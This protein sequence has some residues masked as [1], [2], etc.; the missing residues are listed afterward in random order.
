MR[1]DK[2]GR[3]LDFLECCGPKAYNGLIKSLGATEQE[4]A[5][6]LLTDAMLPNSTRAADGIYFF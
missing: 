1:D 4:H 5:A 6:K 2:I 3:L